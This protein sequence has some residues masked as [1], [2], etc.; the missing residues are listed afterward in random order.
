VK[1]F[2]ALD[3]AAAAR[4]AAL[5][6]RMR[7]QGVRH[8]LVQGI[9]KR[10]RFVF[11]SVRVD[12]GAPRIP[13]QDLVDLALSVSTDIDGIGFAT[14]CR[15]LGGKVERLY[16]DDHDVFDHAIDAAQRIHIVHAYHHVAACGS[17]GPWQEDPVDSSVT[18]P[19]CIAALANPMK[20]YRARY[21][22][23]HDTAT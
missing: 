4:A 13:G 20:S 18:C 12:Y 22:L 21:K 19:M 6:N 16:R 10:R 17:K 14:A 15:K 7:I 3:S 23:P 5:L 11:E 8:V 2:A 1:A 9:W